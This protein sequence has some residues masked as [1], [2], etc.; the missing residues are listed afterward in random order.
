MFL[1]QT[2][3]VFF[4]VILKTTESGAFLLN[5]YANA[6]VGHPDNGNYNIY[7]KMDALERSLQNL[8]TF[9]RQKTTHSDTLMRQV[10][11]SVTE[12]DAKLESSNMTFEIEKIKFFIKNSLGKWNCNI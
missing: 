7:T 10:L 1:S 3:M 11:L 4:L 6:S 2:F 5:D 9:V 12:M 8:E